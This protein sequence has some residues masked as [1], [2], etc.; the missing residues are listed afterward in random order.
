MAENAHDTFPGEVALAL[1][2]WS[3]V[4]LADMSH[5]YRHTLTFSIYILEFVGWCCVMSCPCWCVPRHRVTRASNPGKYITENNFFFLFIYL[6]LR[7]CRPQQI[8][9]S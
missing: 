1:Q 9:W 2:I 7:N 6:A 5:M 3:C 4:V 8:F